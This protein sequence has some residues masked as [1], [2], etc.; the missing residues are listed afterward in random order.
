M[1]VADI[2]MTLARFGMLSGCQHTVSSCLS[3][4]L[5]A[6]FANQ[7]GAPL[8]CSRRVCDKAGGD[9]AS[10]FCRAVQQGLLDEERTG[11]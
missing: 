2:E 5:R 11:E 6:A 10:S 3:S 1:T 9:P 7:E 8:P 4:C